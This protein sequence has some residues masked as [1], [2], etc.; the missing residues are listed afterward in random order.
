MFLWNLNIRN[1]NIKLSRNVKLFFFCFFWCLRWRCTSVAVSFSRTSC[2]STTPSTFLSTLT[3]HHPSDVTRTSLSTGCWLGRWV[4][5]LSSEVKYTHICVRHSLTWIGLVTKSRTELPQI[6]Q[7]VDTLWIFFS[8]LFNVCVY[9]SMQN[10]GLIWGCQQEK[11]RNRHH[12]AMTKRLYPR[13]SRSSALNSS[14]ECLL[15]WV[16]QSVTIY[17][18]ICKW[19]KWKNANFSWPCSFTVTII[20][21][22]MLLGFFYIWYFTIC[23]SNIMVF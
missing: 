8:T 1:F 13:E 9:I 6:S 5:S 17:Y 23:L 21:N 19:D 3:S 12:T 15:R 10:V 20:I 18:N 2:L 22:R 4:R 11:S 14:L 7:W 16:H